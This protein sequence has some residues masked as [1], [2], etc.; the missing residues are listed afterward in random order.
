M[1]LGALGS[2]TGGSIT[3][4]ASYCG[5]A[6]C[7]P[8]FGRVSKAGVVPLA[9]SMDHV[10]PMAGCVRDLAI[11]LQTIAGRDRR[12][13]DCTGWQVPDYFAHLGGELPPPKLGRVR[14]LFEDLAE[15]AMRSLVDEVSERLKSHGAEVSDVALP[16]GFAEVNRNHRTVMAVEAAV[17]HGPRL[18]RHPED[19]QPRIR[20]LLEEGLAC[21]ALEYSRCKEHQIQLQDLVQE[22]F[23]SDFDAW[24]TPATRG[25]APGAATTGDPAFNAPWS[26]THLPTVSFCAGRSADGL[27][28]AIQLVGGD[29]C[30]DTLFRAAAWCE[31]VLSVPRISPP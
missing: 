21:P 31:D 9:F 1:C 2:Q 7:K 6:G 3:R 13:N 28:S 11:I 30:E 26:Y 22:P 20:E 8:T 15:P 25:P 5:V 23:Y 4:P 19:Y 29:M 10:G 17:F 27:P 18:K 24:L 12:D 16:A 14:G